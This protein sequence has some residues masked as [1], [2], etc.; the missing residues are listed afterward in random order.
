AYEHRAMSIYEELGDKRGIGSVH[1]SIGSVYY[2]LGNFAKSMEHFEKAYAIATHEEDEGL[3]ENVASGMGSVYFAAGRM[4]LAETFFLEHLEY[5]KISGEISAIIWSL[6]N[7]ASFYVQTGEPEKARAQLDDAMSR[8]PDHGMDHLKSRSLFLIGKTVDSNREAIDYTRQALELAEASGLKELRWKFLTDL[9]V[10]YRAQG[11]IEEAKR[12]Q[13]HAINDIEAIRRHVGSDELRRHMLRP[14]MTPFDRMV[15]L[16]VGSSPDGGAVSEAFGYTE[17]SKA[18]IFASLLR[19]ALNRIGNEESVDLGERRDLIS[20]LSYQQARLQDGT[21]GD[22]E[23][24]SIL[25]EMARLERDLLQKEIELAGQQEDYGASVYPVPSDATILLA[26]LKPSERMLAYFLGE[27]RSFLFTAKGAE[28]TVFVLPARAEIEEKAGFYIRLL[29]QTA[30]EESGSAARRGQ[31]GLPAEIVENA[32]EELY[33]LLI[34]PAADLLD[35]SETLVI[36]PDGIL[37]RLP[38]AL[39]RND[40]KWLVA[41]HEISYT[42]SLQSLLYLRKR[43]A[44]R[45][46][47]SEHD[48]LN[49]IAFGNSGVPGGSGGARRVYPF[50]DIVIESLPHAPEEAS[51]IAEMFPRSICLTDADASE[52]SFK[53]ANLERAEILHIAAHSYVDNEDVR[54]SFIVLGPEENSDVEDGSCVDDGLLQWHEIA[55]LRLSASLVT[56]SACRAAGGVLAYGEGITGFTQAFLYAGGGCVLA[57]FIDVPDRFAGRFMSAFYRHLKDGLSGAAALR[58]A[59]IEAMGWTDVAHGPALWGSFALIGDGAFAVTGR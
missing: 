39:L 34:A 51:T 56:L 58:A 2:Y 49:V 20:Q 23:R 6:N 27:E 54:R 13:E 15:S 16:I 5:S 4:D 32:S 8:F 38:F 36:I 53:T 44:A 47:E 52:R 12:L 35:R 40:G 25:D 14:A 43:A 33:N 28:L 57:S 1:F 18:Q 19:E 10:Y 30:G 46:S 55:G 26:A 48:Q 59:Q 17:R 3:L 9:G 7:I 22:D 24:K 31:T 21:L 37:N 42:P 11:D 29:R 41:S 45:S 50:T